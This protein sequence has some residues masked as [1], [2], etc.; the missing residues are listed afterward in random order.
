VI[1]YYKENIQLYIIMLVWLII[2]MYGGP[3]IYGILPLT[4]LLMRK[5]EM[6][7]ELI[8]GYFFILIL[9]DSLEPSLFFAKNVKNIYVSM[10]AIFF[11]LKSENFQPLNKLYNL[12][13]PFFI[14]S[15]YTMLSSVKEPFFFISVQKTISYMLM[16]IVV[17]NYIIKLYREQG[18]QL[19]KKIIFFAVTTLI[20]GIIL[21]YVA[22]DV[23]Y[24]ETGRYRGVMGNPNGLGVYCVLI[25][26]VFFVIDNFFS[27]LFTR[28]ERILFFSVILY[29]ILITGSRNAFLAVMLF[30]I[31]QRFFGF[32]PF[33]GFIIFLIT[34][35][36]GEIISSNL[37][38]IILSLHLGDFFRIKTLAEGSGRYIAWEFAWQQIQHNFFIGKGFAY[39]EYY[40][41]QNYD[42][43]GKLGHQGGIHN[44]FLTFWMDQGLIGLIIY[45]RSFILMFIKSA[46]KTKFAFPIMFT[47][48]FTA[49]FESWLVGSLSA[50]AFLV[51]ILYTIIT[52]DEIASKTYLKEIIIT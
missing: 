31:F 4:M 15:I 2:G 46:Q 13:I 5:K 14:F 43:L 8:I 29:S 52:S 48:S 32:S 9:S 22:H 18:E 39:N 51:I 40:M 12:F 45:L 50:Y 36:V 11:F 37:I 47:I 17:P 3:L 28:S 26:I 41:R 10:L 16:F 25:F 27:D 30:F 33:L 23:A 1:Q 6:Y 49:M 35:F 19:F 44:S 42:L 24:I 21:K 20:L 34:L 38:P 7:E